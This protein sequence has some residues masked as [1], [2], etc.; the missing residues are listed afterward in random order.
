[1][2]GVDLTTLD[3]TPLV[4]YNGTIATGGDSVGNDVNVFY[5]VSLILRSL[6]DE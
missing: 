5:Q 3:Y 1:M 4:P 2:S 6:G